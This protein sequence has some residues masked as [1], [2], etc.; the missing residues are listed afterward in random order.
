MI[1]FKSIMFAIL[2][3][4]LTIGS[5]SKTL[6]KEKIIPYLESLYLVDACAEAN[7]KQV[8]ITLNIGEVTRQDSLFGFNFELKYDPSKI[9]FDFVLWQ[10]TLAEDFEI[11]HSQ[12]VSKDSIIFGTFGHINPSLAPTSGNKPLI[13]IIGYWLGNC[14]DS[15]EISISYLEYT[16]EFQKVNG[17]FQNTKVYAKAKNEPSRL[18]E[19]SF[20]T[21]KIEFVS[22]SSIIVKMSI[23]SNS[24]KLSKTVFAL[25]SD[26]IFFK[27]DSIESIHDYFNISSLI[28]VGGGKGPFG[29]SMVSYINFVPDGDYVLSFNI[30]NNYEF[31]EYFGNIFV[32]HYSVGDCD[33]ISRY[34]SD[35]IKIYSNRIKIP[36]D[37][38]SV[39][40]YLDKYAK[41][42]Y[43]EGTQ[44][45]VIERD[46]SSITK[47]EIFDIQGKIVFQNE[48]E[49]HI[50]RVNVSNYQNG[51]Y[52]IRITESDRI[53]KIKN[54]IKY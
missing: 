38:T 48:D 24:S 27:L 3:L 40:D 16:E 19:Y 34:K 30:K 20:N 41:V 44:E 52:S 32:E 18:L 14:T 17:G 51:F 33:C 11:K 53:K 46:Y 6:G 31:G 5:S 50:L 37:T 10:N 45:F 8:L 22:D 12:I 39:V 9:R 7:R 42:Y 23:N 43:S 47:I 28:N 21:K 54:L 1:F 36:D 4:I 26:E 15:S 13:A 2:L 49:N 29:Y 35:T 25:Y